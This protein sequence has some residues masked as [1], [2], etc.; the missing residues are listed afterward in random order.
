[1]KFILEKAVERRNTGQVEKLEQVI[2]DSCSI[3]S[4]VGYRKEG[5]RRPIIMKR[6]GKLWDRRPGRLG[7]LGTD[8]YSNTGTSRR[9]TPT[10]LVVGE[11][12]P[13][14]DLA[15]LLHYQKSSSTGHFGLSVE[16]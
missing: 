15:P 4:G 11:R 9:F 7:S 13:R 1:M 12:C 16:A 8:R 10:T 5:E 3:D 14:F 6:R 2:L